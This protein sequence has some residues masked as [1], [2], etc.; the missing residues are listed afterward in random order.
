MGVASYLDDVE[1]VN[2]ALPRKER[3]S[4]KKFGHDASNSPEV[5]LLTIS[6]AAKQK[7]WGTVPTG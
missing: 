1:L 2:V 5:H 7:L 3:L 4:V 6:S